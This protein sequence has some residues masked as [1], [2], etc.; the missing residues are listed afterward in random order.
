MVRPWTLTAALLLAASPALAAGWDNSFSAGLVRGV[1]SPGE[2]V[3]V[4]RAGPP[5]DDLTAAATSL[6]NALKAAGAAPLDDSLLGDVSALDD[7]SLVKKAVAAGAAAVAAVHVSDGKAQVAFYGK[8]GAPRGTLT[9]QRAPDAA[10]EPAQPQAQPAPAQQPAPPLQPPRAPSRDTRAAQFEQQFVGFGKYTQLTWNGPQEVFGPYQGQ[11]HRPLSM[12]EFF[13]VVGRHDLSQSYQS[14]EDTRDT[15]VIGGGVV[16]LLSLV[17]AA[18]LISSAND[19]SSGSSRDARVTGGVVAG[20]AGTALGGGLV[21]AGYLVQPMPISD[22]EA[23]E[24]AK[25]YDE[26]LKK[27]LNLGAREP[28]GLQLRPMLARGGAGLGLGLRF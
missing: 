2:A 22:A 11:S 26:Q 13:E 12:P 23:M 21:A 16:I 14:R 6:I 17:T 1:V 5:S 18:A 4:V 28:Q 3:M 9:A 20:V 10:A 27:R 7:A 15:L 8:D 25:Q 19:A 24:L